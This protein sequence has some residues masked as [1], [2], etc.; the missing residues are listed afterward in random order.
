MTQGVPARIRF[1]DLCAGLGGFHHALESVAPGDRRP[2]FDCVF[3]SE[4]D[5]ELRRLYLRNF[6]GIART[7]R[8]HFPAQ[9]TSGLLQAAGKTRFR[10]ALAIYDGQRL[11]RI[12]GDLTAFVEDDDLRR[13]PDDDEPL[14]PEHDLLFAGFPCQPFSKSGS[15]K[16]F[17]DLRGTVFH[18]IAVILAIRRPALVLL[19]NVGNFDRHDG[20]RTWRIVHDTLTQ[21]LGYEVTATR[22]KA[23]QGEDARGLLSPHHLGFPH[24]RERFFIV[25]QRRGLGWLPSLTD[26]VPFPPRPRTTVAQRRIDERAKTSLVA[27]IDKSWRTADPDDL[28]RACL[29][30][31]QQRCIEH[32]NRL[33]RMMATKDRHRKSTPFRDTMPSFPIW[34]FELDPWQWYPSEENPRPTLASAARASR[35]RLEELERARGQVLEQTRDQ[36]DLYDYPPSGSRSFL[37]LQDRSSLKLWIDSVPAYAKRRDAWPHWKVQFIRQNREWAIRLWSTLDPGELRAWLDGLFVEITAASNQKLEWNCKGEELDLWKHVLQFRPS[38]LRVKRLRHIPALVA[39]TATQIPVVPKGKAERA[40]AEFGRD[41]RSRYLLPQEALQLQGFPAGWH[42]PEAHEAAFRAFGNAVHCGVVTVILKRWLFASRDAA[43][44]RGRQLE[45]A[46]D[47][48]AR[49]V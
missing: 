22:H 35:L 20:G 10:E 25:A 29:S 38:G 43:E 33:L 37:A 42:H 17:K 9:R 36:V 28:A 40:E 45:M 39:M 32:W 7:Y 21:R 11:R 31:T 47:E 23:S 15:Q 27:I 44:E 19:E 2:T 24:H 14:I 49:A 41:S 6:P 5:E 18:H 30:S 34:G 46:Y 16:G 8:R 3:A 12:H 48:P 26:N 13:W 4:L 1:V